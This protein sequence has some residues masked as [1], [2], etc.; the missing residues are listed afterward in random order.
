MR[1]DELEGKEVS[2]PSVAV[3]SEFV[4]ISYT[5]GREHIRTLLLPKLHKPKS[6]KKEAQ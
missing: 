4:H 5:Y 2:Y 3:N 1:L 6:H